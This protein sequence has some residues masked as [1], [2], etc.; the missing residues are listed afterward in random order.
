LLRDCA[1]RGMRAP[2][3][4]IGDGALGF[5]NGLH[6]VCPEAGEGRCWFRK[7]AN[8]VAAWPKSAHPGAKEALAEIW[9]GRSAPT[10]EWGVRGLPAPDVTLLRNW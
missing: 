6:K 3:L 9:G 7:T 1:R 8:V 10:C 4:A 2:V 5:W